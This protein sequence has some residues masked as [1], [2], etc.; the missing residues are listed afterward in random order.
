MVISQEKK[1]GYFGRCPADVVFNKQHA[2]SD[3][4]Y[5]YKKADMEQ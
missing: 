4:Q 5:Y 2:G 3:I 1:I